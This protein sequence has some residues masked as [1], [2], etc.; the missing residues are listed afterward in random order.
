[1]QNFGGNLQSLKQELTDFNTFTVG[2]A[3]KEIKAQY[4]RSVWA[5][6]KLVGK[7]LL[8]YYYSL[9]LCHQIIVQSF[10]G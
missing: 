8:T 7:L 4:F 2:V 6:T 3:D 1:M 10:E 5:V 9:W